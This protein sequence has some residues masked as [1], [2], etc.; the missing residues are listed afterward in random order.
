[1]NVGPQIDIK[2][3]KSLSTKYF[4]QEESLCFQICLVYN[5]NSHLYRDFSDYDNYRNEH[6]S[7][8]RALNESGEYTFTKGW[9]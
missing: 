4:Y 5:D 6:N 7:L 1:M 8:V 9:K 2:L 3:V